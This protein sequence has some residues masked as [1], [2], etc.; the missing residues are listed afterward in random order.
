[1]SKSL[2]ESMRDSATGKICE[3]IFNLNYLETSFTYPTEREVVID[4]V[5]DSIRSISGLRNILSNYLSELNNH[6]EDQE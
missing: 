2:L 6:P 1:M 5:T 3:V 4:A